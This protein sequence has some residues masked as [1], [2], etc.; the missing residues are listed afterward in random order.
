[1]FRAGQLRAHRVPSQQRFHPHDTQH[2]PVVLRHQ[3]KPAEDWQLRLADRVT[4]FAGSMPF[5]WVHV[6]IFASWV[7]FLTFVVSLEAIL[8]LLP[9]VPEVTRRTQ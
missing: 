6:A 4:A 7:A 8:L 9:S 1:M 5:V 2:S 3:V